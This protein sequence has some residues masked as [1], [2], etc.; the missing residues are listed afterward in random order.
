VEERQ[1]HYKPCVLSHTIDATGRI[2]LQYKLQRPANV[3]LTREVTELSPRVSTL[4]EQCLALTQ[5]IWSSTRQSDRQTRQSDQ[6]SEDIAAVA[7]IVV[8]VYI[9]VYIFVMIII[10]VVIVVVIVVKVLMLL[11]MRYSRWEQARPIDDG[12]STS[13]S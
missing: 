11:L 13:P 3:A 9:V 7:V 10:I 5:K 1:A 12:H 4:P 2:H 8:I 6:V